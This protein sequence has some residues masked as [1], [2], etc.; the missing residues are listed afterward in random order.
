MWW[1]VA[2][3]TIDENKDFLYNGRDAHSFPACC[4]CMSYSP[5]LFYITS[6]NAMDT[7]KPI[8]DPK[9][10]VFCAECVPRESDCNNSERR[11][12]YQTT[13]LFNSEE[14][15]SF[16]RE[17]K[18]TNPY[19]K[20]YRHVDRLII[21]EDTK[22]SP[23][24]KRV[25]RKPG[26]KLVKMQRM[27]E[28]FPPVHRMPFRKHT[29]VVAMFQA[30]RD[31]AE[32]IRQFYHDGS[33]SRLHDNID[34]LVDRTPLHLRQRTASRI[35]SDTELR[36]TEA[37]SESSSEANSIVLTQESSS[38]WRNDISSST[39]SML[40]DT[41]PASTQQST[42][43]SLSS[44][45]SQRNTSSQACHISSQSVSST[46][47]NPILSEN[48]G[49]EVPALAPIEDLPNISS[50]SSSGS[51]MEANRK[52]IVA[53][54]GAVVIHDSQEAGPSGLQMHQQHQQH[55][56]QPEAAEPASKRRRASPRP[57]NPSPADFQRGHAGAR[58]PRLHGG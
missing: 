25:L 26:P 55:Q 30:L 5:F 1:L 34:W 41:V 22:I 35:P 50:T 38:D 57:M 33:T 18:C 28:L 20:V 31:K 45:M 8:L 29:D 56:N 53:R 15:L 39:V 44:Q 54:R 2:K 42:F 40:S 10:N 36:S 4:L 9:L 6:Q 19:Y 3:D 11:P 49:N 23:N 27:L 46:M 47:D 7:L 51:E 58:T 24:Y 21:T 43:P 12:F 14:F 13:C 52:T 17:Y 37:A 48:I 16:F 32:E